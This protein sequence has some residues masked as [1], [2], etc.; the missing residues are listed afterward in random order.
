MAPPSNHMLKEMT[1]N[2]YT[3]EPC[4]CCCCGGSA[5][6]RLKQSGPCLEAH[7]ERNY[8]DVTAAIS[9]A[10]RVQAHRQRA[11]KT[12]GRPAAKKKKCRNDAVPCADYNVRIVQGG[13]E[14]IRSCCEKCVMVQII[15]VC[16]GSEE[17]RSVNSVDRTEPKWKPGTARVEPRTS[18]RL[19]F[20][21]VSGSQKKSRLFTDLL[22]QTKCL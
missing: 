6:L 7:R 14:S 19:R 10:A 8:M 20:R 11:D 4:S 3:Q 12:F 21:G 16:G 9:S 1:S 15:M 13:C 22:T 5:R 17:M 2:L 18:I